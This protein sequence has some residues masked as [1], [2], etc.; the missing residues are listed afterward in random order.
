MAAMPPR[1]DPRPA[2]SR[3]ASSRPADRDAF[4]KAL[5]PGLL[6]AGAAVGVSHLVQSTRAGASYG[7]GL[8]AFVVVAN[9]L[10]YPAFA[11]GPHYAAATGTS[12]VEGYR[13]QGRW[14]LALY[15]LVTVGTMLSVQAAVTV[16]TA[17]LTLNLLGLGADL[18]VPVS[19]AITAACAALLAIGHY[20]WLDRVMKVVVVVLTVSTLA[21]TALALPRLDWSALPLWPPPDAWNPA[22][23][24]FIAALVGWM[25]SAIDISVWH[26]LWTLARRRDSGHAPTVRQARLDFDIGYF[27]AALLAVCFVLLG[28]AVMHGPG[29]TLADSAPAFA[30]QV[31]SLY[32]QT[33]GA[34]SGPLIAASALVVML[35]TTLTVLDGWPRALTALVE[36]LSGP[37]SPGAPDDAASRPV[38]WISLVVVSAGA[39]AILGLLLT[40]LKAFV[41]LA[42]TLS[43]LTA[44]V[45]AILNHRAVTGPEVAAPLRPSRGLLALSRV[46]I[47]FLTVFAL[48][49]L[50]LRFFAA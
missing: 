50:Y 32:T 49:Y 24:F 45:L 10:K 17:A 48:G 9:V 27:G 30:N 4:W 36:R 13:R 23:V 37:E 28:A 12:L 44:P 25:P 35:S 6:F 18:L 41:D 26:S 8:L 42:T 29:V 20:R 38:Y 21:A 31:V 33:L 40:E 46:G 15:A 1:I 7:L 43:F 14:A 34:W 39:L 22:T 5:G 47:V 2:P 3:P 16:V 11:F 19:A